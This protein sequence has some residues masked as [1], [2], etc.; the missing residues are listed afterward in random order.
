MSTDVDAAGL[1]AAHMRVLE[2]FGAVCADPDNPT[3]AQQ[4]DEALWQ[5]DELLAT[6]SAAP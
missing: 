6:E 1:E 2:M 4:A 3:V 5:L